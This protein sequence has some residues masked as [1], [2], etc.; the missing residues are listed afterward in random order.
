MAELQRLVEFCDILDKMLRDRLI[1]GGSRPTGGTQEWKTE[2]AESDLTLAKAIQL[3][4]S[5]ETAEK[6]DGGWYPKDRGSDWQV[7]SGWRWELFTPWEVRTLWGDLCSEIVFVISARDV[8]ISPECVRP[9][10]LPTS[11]AEAGNELLD[12]WENLKALRKMSWLT[13]YMWW[14]RWEES[15]VTTNPQ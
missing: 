7:H 1:W 15:M 2:E 9:F 4:Q 10:R 6:N 11:F 3:A 5:M 12:K 14:K 8:D 13:H